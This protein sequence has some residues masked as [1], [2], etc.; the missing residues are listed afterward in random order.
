MAEDRVCLAVVVGAHGVKGL[1]KAKPFTETPEAVAAYGPLSDEAGT[2]QWAPVFK[3]VVKGSVLL[4]LEG[5]GDREAAE[6]LRGTRLYVPRARLPEP[7]EDEVYHAD[8]VGLAAET[9]DGKPLGRVLAVHNYG[10]GDLIEVGEDRKS[11]VLYPFTRQVVPELDLAGGRLVI[12]P[13]E[14]V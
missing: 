10:A 7:E 2:R 13:P 4:A 12:D 5:V 1:V 14:E 6:A 11:A 8:L 9:V 3:G